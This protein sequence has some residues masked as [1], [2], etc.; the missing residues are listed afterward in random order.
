LIGPRSLGS[1][2]DRLRAV[3]SLCAALPAGVPA[4]VRLAAECAPEEIA[5]AFREAIAEATVEGS[6]IRRALERTLSSLGWDPMR[7]AVLS[8]VQGGD[9]DSS[10]ETLRRYVEAEIRA[11]S[12]DLSLR[13]GVRTTAAFSAVTVLAASMASGSLPPRALPPI[14][15]LVSAILLGVSIRRWVRA[16]RS[17]A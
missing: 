15:S 2:R 17:R 7:E 1:P 8:L 10:L 4:A 9:L 5:G 6:P 16:W 3:Y 12:R 14:A 11:E 13:V